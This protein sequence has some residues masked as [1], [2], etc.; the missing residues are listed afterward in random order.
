[1][2]VFI[3]SIQ[4]GG[5]AYLDDSFLAA[6]SV[7]FDEPIGEA[8]RGALQ[9][10]QFGYP[11]S[12][13][14][15]EF[16][17]RNV[18]DDFLI[19][20]TGFMGTGVFF[21]VQSGQDGGYF[22]GVHDRRQ[23]KRYLDVDFELSHGVDEVVVFHFNEVQHG[24]E[25]SHFPFHGFRLEACQRFD[26]LFQVFRGEVRQC[27]DIPLSGHEIGELLQIGGIGFQRFFT[28]VFFILG[29]E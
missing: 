25:R 8:D 5:L 2:L 4:Y 17:H 21:P 28:E 14:E 12:G 19:A 20:V 23:Q 1:M 7:Y 24:L 13:A 6:F 29:M 18:A 22:H 11:D 16:H 26:V 10:A 3:Q 15:Q 27:A 9:V